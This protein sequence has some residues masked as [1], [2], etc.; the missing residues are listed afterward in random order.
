[1]ARLTLTLNPGLEPYTLSLFVAL[2][3]DSCAAAADCRVPSETDSANAYLIPLA[4][5]SPRPQPITLTIDVVVVVVAFAV[6][7]AS[8]FTLINVTFQLH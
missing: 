5:P 1:M 6:A 8:A 3:L 2:Q 7:V 4:L